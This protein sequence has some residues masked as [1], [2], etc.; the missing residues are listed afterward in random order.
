M[1]AILDLF[2]EVP[3]S[4]VQRERIEFLALRVTSLEKEYSVLEA[5]YSI[6]EAKYSSLEKE[7]LQLKE[8]IGVLEIKIQLIEREQ[9]GEYD[10]CPYCRRPK[11]QLMRLELHPIMGDL[12]F[13]TGYYVCQ[14]CGKEYDQEHEP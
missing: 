12:G 14:N 13:K 8:Q 4:V 11:G 10:K 6:L 3:L 9:E 5:K 7:N 1:S 2:K